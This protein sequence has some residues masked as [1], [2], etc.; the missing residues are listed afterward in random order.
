MQCHI[1]AVRA[2][3][4]GRGRRACWAGA[5]P[6]GGRSPGVCAGSSR[7][8]RR[9]AGCRPARAVGSTQ[10]SSTRQPG[11]TPQAEQEGGLWVV[12]KVPHE[13]GFG[14]LLRIEVGHT[15]LCSIS[16][17]V[18]YCSSLLSLCNS[19]WHRAAGALEGFK[20]AA[21]GYFLLKKEV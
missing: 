2:A 4:G 8:W 3:L 20:E 9:G 6:Q 1:C 5:A 21:H 14:E 12:G 7:R 10:R 17:C 13:E 11:P 16:W 15:G 18:W 19:I